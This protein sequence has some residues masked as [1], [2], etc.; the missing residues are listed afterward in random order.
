MGSELY[1]ELEQ[2]TLEQLN[3]K[4]CREGRK[5]YRVRHWIVRGPT[6]RLRS[7]WSYKHSTR[8]SWG[9]RTGNGSK[10]DDR[11]NGSNGETKHLTVF[12]HKKGIKNSEADETLP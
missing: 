7:L 8:G 10:D 3:L 9:S 1:S 2:V 11:E 5:V 12:N 6:V 4:D